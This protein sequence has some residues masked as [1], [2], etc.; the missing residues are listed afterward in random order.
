MMIGK[1]DTATTALMT[2]V[3]GRVSVFL[4]SHPKTSFT[5]S[6]AALTSLIRSSSRGLFL[7][8]GVML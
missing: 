3:D 8:N 4:I 6:G 7:D 1:L 5:F 2:K